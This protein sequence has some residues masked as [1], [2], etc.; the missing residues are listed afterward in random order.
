MSLIGLIQLKCFV[1]GVK[2]VGYFCGDKTT[3]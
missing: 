2:P 1:L 3:S